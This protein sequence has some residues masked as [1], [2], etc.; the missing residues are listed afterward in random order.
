MSRKQAILSVGHRSMLAFFNRVWKLLWVTLTDGIE[1]YSGR[2]HAMR[3]AAR[4]PVKGFRGWRKRTWTQ[5]KAQHKL[6]RV[7][8]LKFDLGDPPS[9]HPMHARVRIP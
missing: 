8:F 1:C 5:L 7:F 6:L 4:V 9:M 3:T 2:Q